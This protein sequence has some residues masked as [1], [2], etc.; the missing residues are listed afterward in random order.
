MYSVPQFV[1]AVIKS[2][3]RDFLLLI[4]SNL[5]PIL[6]HFRDIA[7]FLLKTASHPY[8]TKILGV[9]LLD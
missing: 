9:F 2:R 1:M 5:G 6:P 4:H 3:V 8:T 7:G